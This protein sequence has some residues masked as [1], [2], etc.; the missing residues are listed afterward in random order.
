MDKQ[1][2]RQEQ[3]S[4]RHKMWVWIQHNTRFTV[5]QLATETGVS[6]RNASHFVEDLIRWQRVKNQRNHCRPKVRELVDASELCF[7]RGRSAGYRHRAWGRMK[8]S[9]RCWRTIRVLREFTVADVV[10]G[11]EVSLSY[12]GDW[13]RNLHRAGYL[14]QIA[15]ADEFNGISARYL[16]IRN[17]GPAAPIWRVADKALYDPNLDQTFSTEES[18]HGR[19]A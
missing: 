1:Q 2:K 4:A 14:K 7:G 10:Q 19:V 6:Y 9:D 5:P 17:S 3:Q 13:V 18:R 8:G 11:A 15:A 12:A 16:L